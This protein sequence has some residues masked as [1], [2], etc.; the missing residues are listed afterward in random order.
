M[1]SHRNA[2]YWLWFVLFGVV[3]MLAEIVG[4]KGLSWESVWLTATGFMGLVFGAGRFSGRFSRGY[5]L[6]AGLGF[7]VI[8][9]I[10][11]LHNLGITL[12]TSSAAVTG[13]SQT[14]FGL[15]LALPYALIHSVLGFTSLNLGMRDSSDVP[16]VAAPVTASAD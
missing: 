6:L 14:L 10:G 7:T 12:L 1:L 16:V 4:N 9:L 13:D 3:S 15:S 5:D 2:H 11:V 8:G